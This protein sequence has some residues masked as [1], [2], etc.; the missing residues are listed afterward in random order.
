MSGTQRWNN[1]GDIPEQNN[2]TKSDSEVSLFAENDQIID[3]R[4][5][6]VSSI[7]SGNFA[8]VFRVRDLND[9]SEKALKLFYNTGILHPEQVQEEIKL[10][11]S[12]KHDNIPKVNDFNIRAEKPYIVTNLIKGKTLSDK[13]TQYDL[14][15]KNKTKIFVSLL[16]TLIYVHNMNILHCD[17]NPDNILVKNDNSIGLI[18]FSSA[19]NKQSIDYSR[20]EGTFEYTAPE[21]LESNK[22]SDSSDIFS[23]GVT[24][25]RLFHGKH[26]FKLNTVSVDY[27]MPL[28]IRNSDSKI[29][30]I[31]KKC[32]YLKPEDRYKC[33]PDILKDF[34]ASPAEDEA[35]RSEIPQK[36]TPVK[37]E[38]ES[39]NTKYYIY[40]IAILIMLNLL[41]LK[42]FVESM[43]IL[44]NPVR[45]I[46]FSAEGYS[47][48][49]N[50]QNQS[51]S[52]GTVSVK[53]GDLITLMRKNGDK[54]KK[55]SF[56]YD[57]QDSLMFNINNSR[58]VL[59]NRLFGAAINREEDLDSLNN[60]SVYEFH[61]P[62][63][64]LI[65]NRLKSRQISISI[66]DSLAADSLSEN[67][68]VMQL[69]DM[70]ISCPVLK[71]LKRVRAISLNNTIVCS[72]ADSINSE[73]SDSLK[74]LSINN[75]RISNK[76]LFNSLNNLEYFNI[77]NSILP[78]ID[79]RNAKNL[80]NLNL[81]DKSQGYTI[82]YP[83]KTSQTFSNDSTG[84]SKRLR[85]ERIIE[86]YAGLKEKL[87]IFV[88]VISLLI[89]VY[90]AFKLIKILLEQRKYLIKKKNKPEHI[91]TN[92]SD[93]EPDSEDVNPE[94]KEP[95]ENVFDNE[96]KADVEP[97]SEPQH[98]ETISRDEFKQ[99]KKK[100]AVYRKHNEFEPIY[101]IAKKLQTRDSSAKWIKL[102]KEMLKKLSRNNA[103]SFIEVKG[104]SFKIGDF[105]DKS[106]S[107]ALPVKDIMISTFYMSDVPVTNQQFC[108]FLN[109][110]GQHKSGRYNWLN[111]NSRYC[112]IE[113]TDRYQ[114]KLP[115]GDF[116]VI[117]VTWYGAKAYCDWCDCRLPTEAE[118]EFA[119][120]DRGL[121][122]PFSFY[123]KVDR[124][125]ANYLVDQNDN[126]WHSLVPV[127]S[128]KPN[129][130]GLYEM[131]G[132]ILEWC[133]DYYD[134]EYYQTIP[135]VNPL[136]N[137]TTGMRSVRGGAWC[138]EARKMMTYYRGGLNPASNNNFTGFRIV[139]KGT[140]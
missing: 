63:T 14:S 116:P 30:K 100:I 101:H 92:T 75:S 41:L 21:V 48:E 113:K 5:S 125:K 115:Y 137:G 49:V 8:E 28:E 7:G 109:A 86:Q 97:E 93:V 46:Q 99:L 54:L 71:K 32:L 135:K 130:L 64:N 18:D 58:I 132:N 103:L 9:K 39:D 24:C 110:M 139:K 78:Y 34:E 26:P 20:K 82:H 98:V 43:E 69:N 3:F 122:H 4:Y 17:I 59:N 56:I 138:F 88:F 140:E 121:P 6:V 40:T 81:G 108:D 67:I 11:R 127:K 90:Y 102:E 129:K 94:L 51:Q 15:D 126:R 47:V 60:L 118:W 79:L 29:D 33:F 68:I 22:L 42:P 13:L 80:K 117:E 124:N 35:V 119:A 89:I 134:A 111:L 53:P 45:K 16:K 19:R 112:L 85:K 38:E 57:N 91:P 2:N 83:E 87:I 50:N 73:F 107:I 74:F 52:D 128:F 104:G 62:L 120:R 114:P 77:N 10:L 65:V 70:T 95:E 76:S 106:L 23:F 131:S 1:K 72:G 84:N 61:I 44:V 105:M 25:F 36:F 123:G 136:Y 66:K 133:L 31:L 55:F 37:Q 12:L 96:K 27:T